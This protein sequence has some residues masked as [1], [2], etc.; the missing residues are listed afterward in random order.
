MINSVFTH[1]FG[2]VHIFSCL[3]WTA[4]YFRYEVENRVDAVVKCGLLLLS[5]VS[6]VAAIASIFKI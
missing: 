2:I 5:A 1:A 6:V 3:M 4:L